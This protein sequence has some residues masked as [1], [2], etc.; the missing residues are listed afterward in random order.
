MNPEDE[1]Y[2]EQYFDLFL[3][4]GWKQFIDDITG[5]LQNQR[6]EDIKDEAHLKTIQG[7]RNILFRV[8][9]F[10]TG[11]KNHYE[12]LIGGDNAEEV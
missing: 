8:L 10:E 12:A 5:I 9:D 7:E 11:I 4:P 2:Y 6:I 1:K 3:Q